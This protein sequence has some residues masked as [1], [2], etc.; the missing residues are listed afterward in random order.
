MSQL[1][2]HNN[3]LCPRKL[4]H[5]GTLYHV[6][7]TVG[8]K[9][10]CLGLFETLVLQP[11]ADYMLPW[12]LIA[13]SVLDNGLREEHAKSRRGTEESI[14]WL[15]L[16]LPRSSQS[17]NK[18]HNKCRRWTPLTFTQLIP[19]GFHMAQLGCAHMVFM[20]TQAHKLEIGSWGTVNTYIPKPH[21]SMCVQ[22]SSLAL[23]DFEFPCWMQGQSLF[24]LQESL[25]S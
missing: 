18:T 15:C 21:I 25:F 12:R 14:M 4:D 11:L 5:L 1:I 7:S 19:V 6:S 3:P 8:P 2:M 23:W 13:D 10:Q 17:Y 9:P 22:Y 16:G 24:S 20:L